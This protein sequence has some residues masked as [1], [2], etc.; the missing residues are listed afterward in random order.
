LYRYLG[1]R[2][3]LDEAF[4]L[5]RENIHASA[6][7]ARGDGELDP[8][9]LHCDRREIEPAPLDRAEQPDQSALNGVEANRQAGDAHHFFSII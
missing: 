8:G 9:T 1:D 2:A 7:A 4:E 3:D 6:G 5:A